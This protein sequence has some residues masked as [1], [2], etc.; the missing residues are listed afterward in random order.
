MKDPRIM[1]T[2]GGHPEHVSPSCHLASFG[3]Q[4]EQE[5]NL[6]SN[7][8]EDESEEDRDQS[9]L[10]KVWIFISRIDI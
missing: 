6:D 5:D 4:I 1:L 7:D 3:K 8:Q 2:G 9:Q 10:L